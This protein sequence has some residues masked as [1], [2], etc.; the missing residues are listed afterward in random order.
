MAEIR[1]GKELDRLLRELGPRTAARVGD[2]A[3]RSA[4]RA[5]VR[6][7]RDRVPVDT[8]ALR[9]SMTVQADRRGRTET[10]RSVKIG[11]RKPVSSRAHLVEFGTVKMRARPF[12][13]PAMEEGRDDAL[14]AIRETLARG[15]AREAERMA[16]RG[17]RR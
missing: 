17:Y 3:L 16:R 12:M 8:G 5:I 15:L 10:K 14:R 11:F 7:A 6:L 9:D 1:G 2:N 13:T 4:G